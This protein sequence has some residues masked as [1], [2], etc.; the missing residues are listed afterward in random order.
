M[1]WKLFG[2]GMALGA[3]LT[4]CVAEPEEDQAPVDIPEGCGFVSDGFIGDCNSPEANPE[5]APEAQP[6]AQPEEEPVDPLADCQ[7]PTGSAR[8]TFNQVMPELSWETA[9]LEDGTVGTLSMKEVYCSERF[10]HINTLLFVVTAG[11]CPSCPQYAQYIDGI[12]EG[13]EEAGVL[14]VWLE[15]EDRNYNLSTSA[16]ANASI[17][18]YIGDS[19]IGVRV[20]DAD[21]L[22]TPGAVRNNRLVQ[23]F[24]TQ[25]I[26]RK[27]DMKII[28]ASTNS[29]LLLPVL[30]I[31]RYPEANWSDPTHN[32]L[33]TNVGDPCT[34]DVDCDAGTLITQCIQPR[35]ENGQPTG[36]TGGY[37]TG[38]TCADD[39][40]CGEGGLCVE[41]ERGLT[42]C[43]KGCDKQAEDPGCRGGYSCRPAAGILGPT[44][45]VP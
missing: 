42:A 9:I 19:N 43:F 35:D 4:G 20:G 25:F 36:W 18:R 21:T 6:E 34:S 24:P 1:K 33:P 15:G 45:C 22:P 11:W 31:A 41:V 12:K 44:A 17:K 32:V 10:A 38:L 27:R 7:Y 14:L 30:Q 39:S 26:V 3:L 5:P 29:D 28:S 8:P 37:C 13:L 16:Q 40:A 2:L 23:A